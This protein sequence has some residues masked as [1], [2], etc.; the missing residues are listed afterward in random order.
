[1]HKH[2][3]TALFGLFSL[4]LAADERILDYRS[5]IQVQRDG[6]LRVTESLRVR[7]EGQQIRRGIYRD[8]P[9]QYKDQ[10]GNRVTVDF[11]PLSVLR[12]GN[13]EPWHSA[14]RDNGVRLWVGSSERLLD[15]GVHDYV[16]TFTTNRQLGFFDQYDQLYFNAIGTGWI[17]PIDRVEVS[18]TLPFDI[19]TES[20]QLDS[21]M[22]GYGSRRHGGAA[23]VMSGNRVLFTP[24]GGLAPREGFT[25]AISWPKG[26]IAEPDL[27]Q[28]LRWFMADNGGALTLLLGLLAVAAWYAWAWNKVGRDP[29]RGVII[30]RFK[31]PEGLSPAACRYVKSM[32]FNRN[33][34]TAAIISLAVKGQ[35]EIEEVKKKKFELQRKVDAPAAPLTAGERAVLDAL[36]PVAGGRIEM[37]NENHKK[38]QA[39]RTALAAELKK[40][41]KGRLFHLNGFYLLP[42]I[43]ATVA[44]AVIAAILYAGPAA[45]IGYAVLSLVLH[46]L[47]A[48]LMRAPT[49]AGRLVMD[50]IEGFKRYLGT[51]EQDRLERMRSPQMTPELFESF[52]PYAYALGVENT[53]CNRFAREMP[54]DVREQGGYHPAWYHGHL[55]G[56]GALHHL[57]DNFSSSF[58]GAIAS[59][60]SPPGSSSGSGGGGFSGGGGGGGGG[61]GW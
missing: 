4:A 1:M 49:P 35:L 34:F 27:P 11:S 25:I 9:T 37:E 21:Y 2:L 22:G 58:S 12:N 53:W 8:F 41:H 6:T 17:F 13:S 44:A 59:A 45:W 18:V 42:P 10:Y 52:L 56:T 48:F 33:A 60:S 24:D 15:P 19:T 36:L 51:A 20:I 61:G 3:L 31:P 43:L 16:I 32:S 26:L 7:A 38:F 47:F 46:L 54:R 30:P 39:A 55:H 23:E 5:D 29:A 40:E 14:K 50:E 57:G 28:K